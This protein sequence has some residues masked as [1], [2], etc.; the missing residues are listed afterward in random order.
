VSSSATRPSHLSSS[1]LL[2]V[3]V[4]YFTH[5]R[6]TILSLLSHRRYVYSSSS[7][8]FSSF[9]FFPIVTSFGG[10]FGAFCR[11]S[12][13]PFSCVSTG[14]C[15]PHSPLKPPPPPPLTHT[16]LVL[17]CLCL[18]S[19]LPPTMTDSRLLCL[20]SLSSLSSPLLD[21][22]LTVRIHIENTS[23][24][25]LFCRFIPSSLSEH[26]LVASISP[27]LLCGHSQSISLTI[28]RQGRAHLLL[29]RFG[30]VTCSLTPSSLPVNDSDSKCS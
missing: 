5:T 18:F 15:H 14:L 30:A 11:P 2:V 1:H 10:S 25:P 17:I 28:L 29:L 20:S 16:F 12:Q 3:V 21:S 8:S 23:G 6:S 26:T 13:S 9:L 4:F 24:F 19:R 27:A 22:F 7:S